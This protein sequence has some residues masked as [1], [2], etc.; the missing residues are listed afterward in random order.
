[1]ICY[2]R[3]TE[4]AILQ[5]TRFC[6]SSALATWS[7]VFLAAAAGRPARADLVFEADGA[8]DVGYSRSSQ[9]D[10][11]TLFAQ[12]RPALGLLFGSPRLVWRAGYLFAGSLTLQGRGTDTYSN[13]ADLSLAAELS[14]RS[15][16]TLSLSV[17]QGGTAFQLSQRAPDAA[18]PGFRAPS[19]SQLY[20]ATLGEQF[21]WEA[22]PE[23]V[24]RQGLTGSLSAPQDA[25]ERA[26]VTAAGS[27]G[28]DRVLVRDAVGGVFRSAFSALRPQL[29]AGERYLKFIQTSLVASWNHDFDATWNGQLVAGVERVSTLGS[30]EFPVSIQPTGS[31]TARYL[32]GNLAASLVVSRATAPNLAL[33]TVSLNHAVTLNGILSFDPVRVRQLAGSI[34]YLRAESPSGAGAAQATE[35]NALQ[36]DVGFVWALSDLFL[37]HGRYSLAYQVGGTGVATSLVH[38]LLVG[39][40]VR[41]ST[42]PLAAPVP[43]IGRRVDGT[44]AVGFPGGQQNP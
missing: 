21:Q 37:V 24:L 40:S 44:D 31:L 23:L 28:L 1:M 19:V 17:L 32:A 33:G 29:A 22:S 14:P 5:R 16:M 42:A 39:A 13:R 2:S 3:A 34:G 9:P 25:L 26:N 36:G 10:S 35:G 11:D 30:K 27:L 15:A 4:R 18:E 38:V 8:V 41:Y 6:H 12:A 20:T 43:T 7:I